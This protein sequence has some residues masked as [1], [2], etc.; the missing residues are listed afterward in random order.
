MFW[1]IANRNIEYAI[2]VLVDHPIASYTSA[3]AAKFRNWLMEQGMGMKTVKRVFATV[4]AIINLDISE[5]GLDCTNAFAKT[6][7]PENG[8][9]AKR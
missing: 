9:E 3:E 8:V 4:R 2:K 6:Y 7:F 5:E 1:P